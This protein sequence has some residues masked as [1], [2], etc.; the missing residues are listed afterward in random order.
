MK[1]MPYSHLYSEEQERM[2]FIHYCL[3]TRE[4]RV[5][6]A[7]NQVMKALSYELENRKK[8]TPK[9]L[10]ALPDYRPL[11]I[12]YPVVIFDGHLYDCRIKNRDFDLIPVDRLQYSTSLHE[13]GFIIDIMTKEALP[14]Y[15]AELGIEM[16]K[17]RRNHIRRTG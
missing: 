7:T 15:L 11:F 14:E 6:E 4:D 12:M 3:F 1:W 13:E 9:L 16:E 8:L 17:I 2:A 10:S 5:F